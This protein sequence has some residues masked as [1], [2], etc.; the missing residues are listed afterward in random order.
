MFKRIVNL[1]VIVLNTRQLSDDVKYV[2]ARCRDLRK[3]S[4]MSQY[5]LADI[6]GMNHNTISRLETDQRIPDL[7][8]L[9]RYCYALNISVTEFLP[10]GIQS[11]GFTKKASSIRTAYAQLDDSYKELALS[12]MDA[13][14]DCLLTQQSVKN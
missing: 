5:D 4:N 1:E 7:E 8:Q 12:A 3:K 14:I 2:S 6:T 13:L 11:L 10:L 9:F